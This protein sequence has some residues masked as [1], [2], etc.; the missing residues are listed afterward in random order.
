MCNSFGYDSGE[1]TKEKGEPELKSK[2]IHACFP[3]P[4]EK[5]LGSEPGI[6]KKG[7][8]GSPEK[9]KGRRKRGFRRKGMWYTDLSLSLQNPYVKVPTP[10]SYWWLMSLKR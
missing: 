8:E 1:S 2:G 3:E 4:L 9:H 6:R 7:R 5:K 10:S